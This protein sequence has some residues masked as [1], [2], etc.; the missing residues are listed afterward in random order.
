MFGA[1]AYKLVLAGFGAALLYRYRQRWLTEAGLWG[2]TAFYT[3][4]M[5]WWLVYLN[6]AEACISDPAVVALALPY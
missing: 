5:V 1:L 2:L 4:V 3:G 6:A